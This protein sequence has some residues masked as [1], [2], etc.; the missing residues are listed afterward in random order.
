VYWSW[1]SDG[2][3]SHWT[4]EWKWCVFYLDNSDEDKGRLR[5]EREE[6]M[7]R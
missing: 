6:A 2:V 1:Q 3:G 4:W 7:D 5:F